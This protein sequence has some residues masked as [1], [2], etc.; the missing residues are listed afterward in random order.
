MAAV[1]GFEPRMGESESQVLPLHYTA[2][3]NFILKGS[4]ANV[5]HLF[6]INQPFSLF[7]IT[8]ILISKSLTKN[9]IDKFKP[10]QNQK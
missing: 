3:L 2:I 10:K 6:A 5:S 8:H 7:K 4:L 9:L 1:L